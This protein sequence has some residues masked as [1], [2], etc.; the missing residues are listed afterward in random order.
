[1]FK[2]R[3]YVCD[4]GGGFGFGSRFRFGSRSRFRFGGGSRGM[5]GVLLDL[6]D[7]AFI[8]T[9]ADRG[10]GHVIL[11]EFALELGD[12]VIIDARRLLDQAV[13]FRPTQL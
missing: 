5:F 6:E 7:L 10:F 9:V 3:V 8:E 13:V 4:I 2:S 12:D 1:M 11:F